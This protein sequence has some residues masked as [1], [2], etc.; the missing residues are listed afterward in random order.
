MQNNGARIVGTRSGADICGGFSIGA[1]CVV[2]GA[3]G[4]VAHDSK[5]CLTVY[6]CF[7]GDENLAVGV[8]CNR[9][10]L[11]AAIIKVGGDYA[12]STEAVVEGAVG[13]IAHDPKVKISIGVGV[14]SNDDFALILIFVD[15][16]LTSPVVA[17]VNAGSGFA[18][19]TEAVVEGA[20][21]VVTHDGNVVLFPNSGFSRDDNFPI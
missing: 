8:N 19:S 3:V 18:I 16:N 9:V 5:V 15:D 21:G 13:V 6:L 10:C 2:E 20:V 17:V 1:E 7:S 4:V 12:I 11:V 14:A